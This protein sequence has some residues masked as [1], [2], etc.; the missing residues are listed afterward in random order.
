MAKTKQQTLEEKVREIVRAGEEIEVE[1]VDF[2]DPN[3]PKTVLEVD[4]PIIPV[5]QIAT[6]E[7]NAG[8]PIYQM[9]KWWARRRS[10]VFRTMLLAAAM[11]SPDDPIKAGEIVWNAYYGNHKKNNA[12]NNLKVADIFMGGGTTLVEGSRLGMQMY[13]N[14]LN[15]VAWLV[16][17]NEFAKVNSDELKQVYEQIEKKVKPQVMPYYSCDCP[18]GHKGR[19]LKF[20]DFNVPIN[21]YFDE[22]T[23]GEPSEKQVKDFKKVVSTFKGWKQWYEDRE[24]EFEVMS[25]DFNPSE[26]PNK[27]RELYRYWGPEMIY[28]FWAK[29]GSCQ[30]I[31]CDHSTPIMTSPVIASKELSVKFWGDYTC[32][33]CN[34]KFDVELKEARIAPSE[35]LVIA[36]DEKRFVVVDNENNF[37]CPTCSKKE[38]I[39]VF[40]KRKTGSKKVKLSLVIHPS[41]L[42]GSSISKGGSVTDSVEDT[43]E[44]N[45]ERAKNLKYIEVRGSLPEEIKCPDTGKVFSTSQGTV[46]KR[47]TFTCQSETCG[48][49]QDLMESIRAKKKS[50]SVSPYMIQGYCPECNQEKQLYGGKFFAKPRILSTNAS[51]REWESRKE[52][53]LK[54]YWPKSELPYGL[55]THVANGNLPENYGYTHW[56]TMFNNQQLLVLSQLLKEIMSI[57]C[58]E[59]LKDLLY[60]MFQQYLRYQNM[61]VFW[62]HKR[63]CPAAHLSNNNYHPKANVV[64]GGVFSDVGTGNWKSTLEAT[65]RGLEWA[66]DPYELVTH[67]YIKKV[68][69]SLSSE[70]KTKSIKVKLKD[71][72]NT[73]NRIVVQTATDLAGIND[74][75]IDLVVTDPPFGNLLHYSELADFFYVWL[76][77]GLKDKYPDN[78]SSEY[79]LKSL[80]AVS[81]RVRNPEKPDAFYRRLLTQAWKEANRILKPSGLLTF[82]FH[83]S[84]DDPW[85]DVLES[86]FEAN[87]YLEATYPIRSDETK[88]DAGQFGSKTIEYDIIHVCRKRNSAE[89]PKKVSWAKMRRQVLRDVRQLQD[90]LQNHLEAGLTESD[91]QVIKRGK[92]LEYY[93][94]HYGQVYVEENRE[95]T[96]KEALVG[97]NQLLN[98]ESNED[99]NPPPSQAEVYTRQF[100]RIFEGTTQV[101][102][103]EMQNYLRGTGISDQFF[104]EKNWCE[105]K[106]KVFYLVSPLEFALKYKGKSKKG[107]SYDLDQAL[108]LIGGAFDNSEINLHDTLNNETFNPHPALAAL[109]EWFH[110]NGGNK[111]TKNAALKA[112]MIYEAWLSRNEDKKQ[113]QLALFDVEEES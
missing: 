107:L 69:K 42:K 3:R 43:I 29:H 105:E 5:N 85:V 60:G 20:K 59:D 68:N 106:N 70:I 83:H 22:I 11:K 97:I 33:S 75:E 113:R 14:D 61:F 2:S 101:K 110:S 94:K 109:L 47:S 64:E 53:D 54:D 91:L 92:A 79:T 55:M 35:P 102:R 46:P 48:R 16:V 15:P 28:T 17:K 77:L 86:L 12:I 63:D 72:V 76:R 90:V 93:S 56:W 89:K 71:K 10:S 18:R 50:S 96:L 62:H 38:N 25:E 44:W 104:K 100:L 66:R 45:N 34:T 30:S 1:T 51:V 67:D 87:F 49:E 8:K 65:V 73:P 99:K 95:F 21:P 9:S 111:E 58:S 37:C 88:G 19:W 78:F 103:N 26:I 41:W 112:K 52:Q 31:G 13:G 81:N 82:T 108:L 24:Y 80:E 57:N 23:I 27:D 84:E 7:G 40:E 6:I 74:N 4:F 98:E 32:S 36:E 39:N